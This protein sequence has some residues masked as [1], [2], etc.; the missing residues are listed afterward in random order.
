M[1][2]AEIKLK[3]KQTRQQFFRVFFGRG[4]IVKICFAIAVFFIFIAIFAPILAPCDPIEVDAMNR[5]ADP[6]TKGHLLGTDKYGRDML[7]RLMYG[8]K[9][10]LT[11]S[12]LSSLWAAVVGSALGIVAGYKEGWIGKLI[13]RYV[14]I[15]LSIPALILSMTLAV[16]LGQ[17]IIAIA[18]VLGIGA[19]PG[20]IRMAYSNVLSIKENDYVV[21]CRLIGQNGFKIMFKHLL[22]NCFASLIVIFTMSL[23]TTI[24]VESSL[25]YLGVG[26]CEPVSAWGLMVSDG[27]G[28]LTTH[29]SVALLPGF[30]IMLIV[31]SFNVLGDGLRD[32]LDP[33]LRGKL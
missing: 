12:L 10:S 13:M 28:C 7:S 3:Q 15:Q 11:C 2:K 33:K 31:V 24:M 32:A 8:A 25:A 4:L 9:T 6:F 29:P 20:Y 17:N 23:G 21:A 16:I 5:Y 18:V 26:L 14:D 27:F 19:I 1:D 22:P 30:C